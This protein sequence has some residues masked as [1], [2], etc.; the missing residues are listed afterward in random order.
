MSDYLTS[1]NL[2]RVDGLSTNPQDLGFNTNLHFF[3]KFYH[4]KLRIFNLKVKNKK[5]FFRI[6]K[7]HD[8]IENFKKYTCT[9][10]VLHSF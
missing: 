3:N 8:I 10:F 4:I 1:T 9:E 6:E 2:L 7:Y 5:Y